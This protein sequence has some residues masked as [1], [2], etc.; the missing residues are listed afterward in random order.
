MFMAGAE[1]LAPELR[2]AGI[3]GAMRFIWRAVQ[4]ADDVDKLHENEGKLFG[5]AS[6]GKE[7]KISDMR[8]HIENTRLATSAEFMTP[9]RKL[10]EYDGQKKAFRVQAL[11]TGGAFDVVISSFGEVEQHN[12]FVRLFTLTC[13]LY[14][15]GRRSRKGFGT[16]VI[17]GIDGIG[18]NVDYTLSGAVDTLNKLAGVSGTANY[19]QISDHEISVN[20]GNPAEYPYIERIM[21]YSQNSDHTDNRTIQQSIGLACHDCKK[22][23][24]ADFLGRSTKPR[25]ASSVLLSENNGYCVITQLHTKSDIAAREPF[26]GKLKEC[27]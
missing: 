13:L 1:Q 9:H 23:G 20:C 3:K 7:T 4:C 11:K 17:T 25:L 26:Y 5:N 18:S 12:D 14:G 22:S 2:V 19:K 15:F 10:Y 27:L 6:G 16:V 8:I 24:K 21:Y